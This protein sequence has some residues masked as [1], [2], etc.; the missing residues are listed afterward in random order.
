MLKP[1]ITLTDKTN[2]KM[3]ALIREAHIACINSDSDFEKP[4][5]N[6]LNLILTS[7]RNSPTVTQENI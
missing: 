6:H 7:T 1:T 5:L 2:M 4:S 3:T